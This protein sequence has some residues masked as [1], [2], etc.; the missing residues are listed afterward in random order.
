MRSVLNSLLS[1]TSRISCNLDTCSC[2]GDPQLDINQRLYQRL[3]LLDRFFISSFIRESGFCLEKT[4]KI[5][6]NPVRVVGSG[7]GLTCDPGLHPLILIPVTVLEENA[8]FAGARHSACLIID[9][10]RKEIEYFDPIGSK[11]GEGWDVVEDKLFKSVGSQFLSYKL[12]SLDQFCPFGPQQISEDA[13]CAAWTLLYLK[14]RIDFPTL[15][16]VSLVSTLTSL[17]KSELNLVISGF[18]CFLQEYGTTKRVFLA[19]DV[20][21]T[22]FE[23]FERFVESRNLEVQDE[24]SDDFVGIMR[25]LE[26]LVD[27]GRFEQVHQLYLRSVSL[28]TE[29]N[30]RI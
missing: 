26:K 19:S 9:N 21:D 25:E 6:L 13:F 2:I 11:F 10:R 27:L 30:S 18:L 7:I 15:S 16:R 12:V 23:V 8:D 4:I 22:I 28:L 20:Y 24:F 3:T 1:E 5:V 14:L 17:S 29:I